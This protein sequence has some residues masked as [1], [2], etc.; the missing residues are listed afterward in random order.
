MP[1]PPVTSTF[2]WCLRRR[3]IPWKSGRSEFPHEH[4]ARV[5]GARVLKTRAKQM[6][7]TRSA[8]V[9]KF[10]TTVMIVFVTLAAPTHVAAQ[11]VIDATTAEFQA[12][13][14]HSAT[15]SD[16]TPLVSSYRLQIFPTGS[17]TPSYSIDIGKP[18]PDSAGLIR[19]PFLS[20]LTTPLVPG[21]IYEARVS[22]VGP[23]G[24]SASL[25]S[26]PFTS[27]APCAP[28]LSTTTISVPAAATSRSV[29]VSAGTT[30]AWTARANDTWITLTSPVSVTGPASVSF[31]VSANASSTGRSGTLTIAGQTFTVT[32]SGA[33]A[34][35]AFIISPVSRSVAAAGETT[36]VTVTGGT[37]CSWTA[38]S[39]VSWIVVTSGASGTANGTANLRV[40]ANSATAGRNATVTIAGQS[41]RVD[42]AGV[43]SFTV[44]PTN[45][46]VTAA[47]TSSTLA[48]A[49]ASGCTW[50]ASGMPSW[51]TMP[52]TTQAGSGPLAYTI[53][54]NPGLARSATLTI[55]GRQVVVAQAAAATGVVPAPANLRVV[56]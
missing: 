46:S 42:Q 8:C 34:P 25:V 33:T 24:T 10:L 48:I 27:S 41:F 49:T 54:A 28:L 26:N 6:A 45:L 50:S 13:A 30:C 1:A 31:S 32:Q 21:T 29:S 9:Y 43:C 20:R 16:G 18:D 2:P 7:G 37:G 44:T 51:I 3:Q 12:S 47:G 14:D 5:F 53:A 40:N 19:F 35:C 39:P 11:T 17:S 55:A 4:T 56:R 52:A 23:G 38:T 15:S 22:A 36:S